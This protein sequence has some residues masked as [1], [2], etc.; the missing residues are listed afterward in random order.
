MSVG[1]CGGF[2]SLTSFFGGACL[3]FVLIV[4]GWCL[5]KVVVEVLLDVV[6]AVG[7]DRI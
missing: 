5:F 4:Y 6:F 1:L 2:G 3:T 7:C